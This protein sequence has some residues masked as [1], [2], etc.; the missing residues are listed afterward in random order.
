MEEDRSTSRSEHAGESGPDNV[1]AAERIVFT[2]PEVAALLGV[3]RATVYRWIQRGDIPV[4]RMGASRIFVPKRP[5]LEQF[6][7]TEQVAV[8]S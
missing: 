3:D 6:G 5:F 1:V 2:I 7:I 4:V 8:S